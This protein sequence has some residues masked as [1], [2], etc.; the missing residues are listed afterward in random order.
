LSGASGSPR[1]R[2]PLHDGLQD[3]ADADAL[4]RAGQDGVAAV[5][6]DDVLDLVPD[7]LGLRARQIDLV[8]DRDHLQIVLDGQVGVRQVCA[9]TPCVASTSSSAPSHAASERVTS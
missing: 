3:V 4:L 7:H 2:Q 9:S 5:E 8:D 1:A 6:S